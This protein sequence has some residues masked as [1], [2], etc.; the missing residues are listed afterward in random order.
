MKEI[1][2]L[3]SLISVV[4]ISGCVD[5]ISSIGTTSLSVLSKNPENYYNK[6]IKISG[7]LGYYAPNIYIQGL[8]LERKIEDNQGYSF[9]IKPLSG[10]RTYYTGNE[11]TL[12]GIVDYIE[13]CVCQRQTMCDDGKDRLGG[14]PTWEDIGVL[15]SYKTVTVS[16]C[17][18]PQED[19]VCPRGVVTT[20]RG[21]TYYRCA[22]ESMSKIYYLKV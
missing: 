11:Y 9:P 13:T 10:E 5:Q 7:T 18:K 22:P 19:I 21:K 4:F 15:T 2:F 14:S 1:Y 8:N 17:E 6:T 16:D 12:T 20:I 3:A